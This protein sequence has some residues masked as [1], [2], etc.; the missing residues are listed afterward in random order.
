MTTIERLARW[1]A[2]MAPAG[3]P[4]SVR[5]RARL[6]QLHL[7]GTVAAV[8]DEAFA[9]IEDPAARTAALCGA[10]EMDDELLGG[11]VGVG[12][13][14]AAWASARPNH[15]L[16][17]IDTAIVA[18]NE[19]AGRVG[20]ATMLGPNLPDRSPLTVSVAAA[21]ASGR[22]MGLSAAVLAH[23]VAL[24]ISHVPAPAPRTRAS[25][26]QVAAMLDAQMVRHG[27][28]AARMASRG[29]RGD[30]DLLDVDDG[31][32]QAHAWLPLRAAF[33]GLGKAWLTETI[34]YKLMPGP[35]PVQMPVQAVGEIL[36]RHVKAADKRLR[37]DQV[38]RIEVRTGALG[39]A[40]ARHRSRP[41]RSIYE[42]I[43]ILV[44]A[45]ELGPQM[46]SAQHLSER[47][48]QIAHIAERVEVVHDGARGWRMFEQLAEVAAPLF[49]DVPGDALRQALMRMHGHL[50]VSVLRDRGWLA[51]LKSRPDRIWERIR[52]A[53]PDLSKARLEEFQFRLD[54]EVKLFTTRGGSW[55]ER[56]AVPEG[57]P[58][59]SW[60]DTIARILARCEE[61][62]A[63]LD[64]SPNRPAA[65]WLEALLKVS[66]TD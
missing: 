21:I 2:E 31:P 54:T 35:L 36:K 12:A 6:Q 58:G 20:A 62:P 59:W 41:S 25:A 22:L 45:H 27:L 7:A 39:C 49:A 53:E 55:P 3:V 47:R 24:A 1:A 32:L 14:P 29:A 30:L 11:R 37:V 46:L 60:E 5:I 16:R 13:V 52:S 4:P 18:A 38:A 10:V 23:A 19:V 15:A 44:D 42:L 51:I 17:E 57:S 43:G 33:T 26:G 64:A 65:E 48:E 50:G 63:L 66:R 28:L 61:G 8:N 9:Q 34:A 40:F 56:R